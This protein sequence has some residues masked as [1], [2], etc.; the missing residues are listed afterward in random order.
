MVFMAV[1]DVTFPMHPSIQPA[2]LRMQKT[3]AALITERKLYPSSISSGIAAE[4][5]E[6]LMRVE[7]AAGMEVVVMTQ[8]DGRCH[9]WIQHSLRFIRRIGWLAAGMG[10]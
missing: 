4:S 8:Q 6:K 10:Q 7:V 1:H 2:H 9:N 3:Y 5:L